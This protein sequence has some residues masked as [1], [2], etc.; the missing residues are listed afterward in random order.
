MKHLLESSKISI[1]VQDKEEGRTAL[2]MAVDRGLMD[3]VEFL[4]ERKAAVNLADNDGQ[5]PLHYACICEHEGV[6]KV[7]LA[8]DADPNI[9]DHAGDTPRDVATSAGLLA[10]LESRT[11]QS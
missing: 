1:N 10:M 7:L 3:V 8:H 9:E 6:V 2:H 5:T 4:L 11:P